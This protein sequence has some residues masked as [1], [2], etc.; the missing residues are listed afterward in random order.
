MRF[1]DCT[2]GDVKNLIKEKYLAVEK[3]DQ[4]K[5]SSLEKKYPELFNVSFLMDFLKNYFHQSRNGLDDSL[6][7]KLELFKYQ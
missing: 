7:F 2:I 5:L 3:N 4:T 6:A 1:S